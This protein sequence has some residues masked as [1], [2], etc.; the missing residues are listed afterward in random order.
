M[1]MGVMGSIRALG[2]KHK[3][4]RRV[5]RQ[6]SASAVPPPRKETA[7]RSPVMDPYEGTIRA[8][9]IADRGVPRKQRHG[10]PSA[11][12][13]ERRLKDCSELLEDFAEPVCQA[14]ER[15]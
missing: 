10:A 6:A 5:V 2:K 4:H 1:A 13:G 7:R 8:W 9:L 14:R 3:V 15:P 12:L 11:A